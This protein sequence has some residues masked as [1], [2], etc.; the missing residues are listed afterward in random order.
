MKRLTHEDGF[1]WYRTRNQNREIYEK[2]K[3]YEDMEEQGLLTVIN[4]ETFQRDESDRCTHRSC[5]NCDKYRR[6]LQRY[7]DLEEQGKLIKLPCAVGDTVYEV[8]PLPMMF[9]ELKEGHIVLEKEFDFNDLKDFNEWVFLT[10]EETEAKLRE[11]END[12]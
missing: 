6:E 5:N 1:E 2:L 12:Y 4:N 10:E 11:L 8:V 3:Y 7:K 9:D